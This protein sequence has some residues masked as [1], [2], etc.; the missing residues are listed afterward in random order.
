MLELEKMFNR[1]LK[2]MLYLMGIY[3]LGVGFTSHDSVFQ[4]LLLGTA[5]S[6]FIFWSMVKK[7]KKF[8]QEVAEGKKTRSL[9]SLTR[10]SVAGLA[11]IIA[12]KYPDDFH[13]VSVILGLMTMYIVIMIDFLVQHSRT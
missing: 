2:Y 11:A 8:A 4:G 12:L 6:L 5:F 10:M 3:L 9:G 7:N 1:Q 13:L